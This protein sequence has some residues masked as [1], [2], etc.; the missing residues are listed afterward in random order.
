MQKDN[1]ELN[2]TSIKPTN[3]NSKSSHHNKSKSVS[4]NDK[5]CNFCNKKGHIAKHCW[6]NLNKFNQSNIQH[7]NF[8]QQP[9]QQ[10]R[11]SANYQNQDQRRYFNQNFNSQARPPTPPHNQRY[12]SSTPQNYQQDYFNVNLNFNQAA[13]HPNYASDYD[14]N[15]D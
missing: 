9:N 11:N 7:Q 8:H 1:V 14:T 2:K 3:D 15:F 6:H 10:G 13:A 12:P 5:I 4:F